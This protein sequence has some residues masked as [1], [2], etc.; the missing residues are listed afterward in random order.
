MVRRSSRGA[1]APLT[2]IALCLILAGCG[3]SSGDGSSASRSGS[4]AAGARAASD[5]TSFPAGDELSVRFAA[6][7]G[8]VCA[9]AEAELERSKPKSASS[10]EI[11]RVAPA[12]A[13][14]EARALGELARLTPPRPIAHEWSLVI[15]SRHALATELLMLASAAKR[16]DTARLNALAA[17]KAKTHA[18]LRLAALRAGVG[19][20][21]ELEV[22]KASK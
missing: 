11:A 14:I 9:R 19:R 6:Q 12:N 20:C 21:A 10:A 4:T 17:S 16:G 18:T 13:A 5:P 2:L 7:A 8:A 3:D 22:A 1:F 15:A